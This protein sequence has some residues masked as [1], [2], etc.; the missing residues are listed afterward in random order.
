MFLAFWYVLWA[1]MVNPFTL[2]FPSLQSYGAEIRLRRCTLWSCYTFS[3]CNSSS[4]FTVYKSSSF[5]ARSESYSPHFHGFLALWISQILKVKESRK[6]A[7]P[8]WKMES[9]DNHFER[10]PECSQNEESENDAQ[11]LLRMLRMFSKTKA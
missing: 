10:C 4:V 2:W 6:I 8:L 9:K 1:R 7:L 5:S 11:N 3:L